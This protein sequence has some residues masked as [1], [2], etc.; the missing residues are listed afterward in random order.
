[1]LPR[2]ACG[3]MPLRVRV[4]RPVREGLNKADSRARRAHRFGA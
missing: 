1:M 4:E 3:A 2:T